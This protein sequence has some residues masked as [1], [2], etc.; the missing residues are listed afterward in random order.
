MCSKCIE[1]IKE[2]K[3]LGC[4]LHVW[5]KKHKM[6]VKKTLNML[7]VLKIMRTFASTTS[8]FK[9]YLSFSYLGNLP[10]KVDSLF[11]CEISFV[12]FQNFPS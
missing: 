5:V 1:I 6:V 9:L 10:V 3:Q 7:V 2:R 11:L 4:I 12:A 8:N